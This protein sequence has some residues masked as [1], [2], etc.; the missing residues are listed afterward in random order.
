MSWI[1]QFV[2][3]KPKA[4]EYAEKALKGYRLGIKAGGTIQGIRV[5]V[6]EESCPT[7]R[8]NAERVF[9]PDDVP[10]LPLAGCTHPDG[11]RCAYTL[12]MKSSLPQG[13]KAS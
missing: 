6:G 4:P 8:A 11:C 10:I 1:Y 13:E 2:R 7:C 3:T 12:A 9:T 5:L